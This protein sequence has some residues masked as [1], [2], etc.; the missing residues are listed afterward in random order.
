MAKETTN[1]SFHYMNRLQMRIEM[2][3]GYNELDRE[4]KY[5][6]VNGLVIGNYPESEYAYY[7]ELGI[8]WGP[9][10]SHRDIIDSFNLL[11]VHV[12]DAREVYKEEYYK[13]AL[14]Y[15]SELIFENKTYPHNES[16]F[17]YKDIVVIVFKPIQMQLREMKESRNN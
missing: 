3:E 2:L 10:N 1:A 12:T 13:E 7:N 17:I 11:G 16:M 4:K 9:A 6:V 15:A 14:D 5:L 8:T